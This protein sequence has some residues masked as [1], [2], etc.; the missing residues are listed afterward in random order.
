MTKEITVRGSWG[1]NMKT[2]LE[3][4]KAAKVDTAPWVTHDFPLDQI[5]EAFAAAVNRDESIKVV[6]RPLTGAHP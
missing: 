5:N 6:V 2:A 1:G 3:L 4:I